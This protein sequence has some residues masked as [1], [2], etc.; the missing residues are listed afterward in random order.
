MKIKLDKYIPTTPTVTDGPYRRRP[1]ARLDRDTQVEEFR[2][3]LHELN[4]R[5]APV[6]DRVSNRDL[7][8]FD[9]CVESLTA[10]YNEC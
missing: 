2:T 1:N 10:Y 7:K 3:P 5:S 4:G 6:P 8:N 9:H